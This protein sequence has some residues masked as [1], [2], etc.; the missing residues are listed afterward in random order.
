K[1]LETERFRG[2]NIFMEKKAMKANP[3]LDDLQE[4]FPTIVV[5]LPTGGR[6]YGEGVLSGTAN[7]EGIEVHTLSMIDEQK[8]KDPLLLAS[9][10]GLVHLIQHVCP[11][12]LEPEELAEVD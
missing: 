10:K 11:D 5:S 8:F 9:G 12:V 7:P 4:T 6:Y 3:L 1:G 2:V